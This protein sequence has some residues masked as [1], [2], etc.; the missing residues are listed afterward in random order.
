MFVAGTGTEYRFYHL[1]LQ[2]ELRGFGL[3]TP[4]SDSATQT[5][6][7]AVDSSTGA[8][9]QRSGASLSVGLSFY[10]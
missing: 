9:I 8:D 2:A 4:K 7:M 10:F 6:N 3:D 5:A 1:A